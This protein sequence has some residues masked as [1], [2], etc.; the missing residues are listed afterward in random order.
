L[1]LRIRIEEEAER[2]LHQAIERLAAD[3]PELAP[4]FVDA[5]EQALHRLAALPQL[6]R[7]YFELGDPRL[8]QLRIWVLRRFGYLIFYRAAEP[9]LL[10]ERVLHCNRDL[11]A[12]FLDD[13]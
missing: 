6:G 10:V 5:V 4:A 3:S 2:D 1:T 12:L 9:D 13:E 8:R 11:L 7:P